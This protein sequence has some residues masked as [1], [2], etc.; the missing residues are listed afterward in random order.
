MYVLYAMAP[1]S[2]GIVLGTLTHLD[3]SDTKGSQDAHDRRLLKGVVLGD[4]DAMAELYN[5]YFPRLFSFLY[6][7]SRDYG[8]TEEVANDA[9][10]VV[11]RSGDKFRGESRVSTW[12]LGI[13][14][15]QCM[16]GLR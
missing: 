2:D 4:E 15:R 6:R 16:N 7:L 10:L 11:W 3:R 12:I 8:L 9:M 5:R 14:Y 13:G 1:D